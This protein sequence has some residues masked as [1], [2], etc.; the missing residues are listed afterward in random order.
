[1]CMVKGITIHIKL[2]KIPKLKKE[3]FYNE[4]II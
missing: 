2:N 1:M 4:K 3:K